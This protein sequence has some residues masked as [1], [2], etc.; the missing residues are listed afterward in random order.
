MPGVPDQALV[1]PREHLQ[2]LYFGAVAGDRTM[3]VAIEADD[4][5][6]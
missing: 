6:Q 5:G 1:R 4:L 3:M 2:A